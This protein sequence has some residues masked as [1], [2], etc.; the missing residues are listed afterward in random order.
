MNQ[1]NR[2]SFIDL[3]KHAHALLLDHPKEI[4]DLIY[5]AASLDDEC[6]SALKFAYKDIKE[7]VIE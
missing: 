4:Q 5:W 3:L 7:S 2:E 6:R 1:P